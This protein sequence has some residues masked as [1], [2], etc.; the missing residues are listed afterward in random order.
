M[1][2]QSTD[3]DIVEMPVEDPD[4]EKTCALQLPH[5]YATQAP[6]MTCGRP[7]AVWV[8]LNN[9][10]CG[11]PSTMYL[12][13]HCWER[14]SNPATAAPIK[15]MPLGSDCGARYKLLQAATAW[16]RL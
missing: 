15:H 2:E 14:H 4:K 12:C 3:R 13:Q 16:R 5:P 8:E 6:P 11:H 7:A 10:P 9:K 1:T